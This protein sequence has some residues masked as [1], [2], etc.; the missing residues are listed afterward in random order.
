VKRKQADGEHAGKQRDRLEQI[1]QAEEARINVARRVHVHSRDEISACH[2]EQ[3]RNEKTAN[4]KHEIPN[5]S[6]RRALAL[7]AHLERNRAENQR[8]EQE[9]QRG[10][11]S[12][13]DAGVN[14]RERRKKRAARR[15]R[16]GIPDNE[17]PPSQVGNRVYA[18]GRNYDPNRFANPETLAAAP[19][20]E[21]VEEKAVSAAEFV[22]AAE[23]K[24]NQEL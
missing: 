22:A 4:G 5:F 1:E 21:P 13:E 3:E 24:E 2:A 23:A 18:R 14:V 6:P 9:N 11:K 15:E 7:T 16:L 20:A 8:T 10:I 17:L 19:A 12:A